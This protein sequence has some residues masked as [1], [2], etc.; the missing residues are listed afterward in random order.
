MDGR[1]LG[2]DKVNTLNRYAYNASPFYHFDGLG[3]FIFS[4]ID[5]DKVEDIIR[6]E[7]K[8]VGRLLDQ[9]L[10]EAKNIGKA[11]E[12][13]TSPYVCKGKRIVKPHVKRLSDFGKPYVIGAS[14]MVKPYVDEA[15]QLVD[16]ASVFA[17]PYL[18]QMMGYWNYF[19][20]TELAQSWNWAGTHLYNWILGNLPTE[21]TYYADK[22][23]E[24][25]YMRDGIAGQYLRYNFYEKNKNARYCNEWRSYVDFGVKFPGWESFTNFP[26]FKLH[27]SR[28]LKALPNGVESYVGSVNGEVLV[29]FI[30]KIN[31]QYYVEAEFRLWNNTNTESFFYHITGNKERGVMKNWKQTFIWVEKIPCQC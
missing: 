18:Q 6:Y 5:L 17:D 24:A 27:F 4:N 15:I 19:K 9:A 13:K 2:R 30:G 22:D 12:R 21:S 8:K 7:A 3:L 25:R 23:I 29:Y 11:I 1:W 31:G 14:N 20:A 28:L 16:S 26:D 10:T